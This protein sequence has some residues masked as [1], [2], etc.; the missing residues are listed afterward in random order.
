MSNALMLEIAAELTVPK[1]LASF[2]VK[3]RHGTMVKKDIWIAALGSGQ[4]PCQSYRREH[5]WSCGRANPLG[6]SGGLTL[7][8]A[9]VGAS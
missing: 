8:A 3:D 6:A 7:G 9:G 1:R 2:E 4:V 5:P